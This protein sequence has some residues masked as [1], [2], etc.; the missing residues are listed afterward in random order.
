MAAKKSVAKKETYSVVSVPESEVKSLTS[1]VASV[2]SSLMTEPTDANEV[3]IAVGHRAL[4]KDIAKDVKA[5]KDG[6][7]K[8]LNESL[9]RV[10][11][12]FKPI[13]EQIEESIASVTNGLAEYNRKA[14]EELEAKRERL[15]ERIE[16]G[17]ITEEKAS[18]IFDKASDKIGAAIIPTRSVRQI[19]IVDESK[20]PDKYWVLDMVAIRRDAITHEIKIPGVAVVIEEQIVNRSS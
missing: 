20:I 16:E 3:A 7:I 17:E 8:P 9:K 19:Q 14:Q 15:D 2:S 4:L 6:I 12:L 10:R 18:R 11:E 5:K 13:E 1:R